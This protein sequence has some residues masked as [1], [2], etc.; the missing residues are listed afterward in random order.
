MIT[1]LTLNLAKRVQCK[2]AKGLRPETS[3]SIMHYQISITGLFRN[4]QYYR[5]VQKL[6]Q[7]TATVLWKLLDCQRIVWS[8]NMFSHVHP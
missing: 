4:Y 1:I 6:A 2:K 5:V 8:K 7:A 3:E